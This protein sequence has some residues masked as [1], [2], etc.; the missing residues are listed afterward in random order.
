MID[1]LFKGFANLFISGS[2]LTLLTGIIFGIVLGSLPGL[3]A[4]MG[5]A[6]LLP[7]TINIVLNQ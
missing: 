1:L 4:T 3:T 5:I 6:L 2:A 7:C